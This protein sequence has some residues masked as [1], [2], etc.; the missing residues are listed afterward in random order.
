MKEGAGGMF[1]DPAAMI[2]FVRFNF[3]LRRT[4][5]ELMHADLIYIR[6]GI[7]HLEN[8]G[9]KTRELPSVWPHLH[10]ADQQDSPDRRRME[11]AVSEGI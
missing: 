5:I 7:N 11:T 8:V 3:L 6:S 9:A 4:L 1:Y 10:R 2:A